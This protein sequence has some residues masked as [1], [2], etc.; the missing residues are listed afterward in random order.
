MF[1]FSCCSSFFSFS[2]FFDLVISS[3]LSVSSHSRPTSSHTI[4]TINQ[5]HNNSYCSSIPQVSPDMCTSPT[6]DLTMINVNNLE[7]KYNSSSSCSITPSEGEDDFSCSDTLFTC[8]HQQEKRK[9]KRNASNLSSVSPENNLSLLRPL[10]CQVKETDNNNHKRTLK[11]AHNTSIISSERT[12]K[13]K[14]NDG[15]FQRDAFTS[16]N[17]DGEN[18]VIHSPSSSSAAAA[19]ECLIRRQRRKQ[20]RLKRKTKSEKREEQKKKKKKERNKKSPSSTTGAAA[21]ASL[22]QFFTL[23]TPTI[24]TSAVLY[25]HEQANSANKSVAKEKNCFPIQTTVEQQ[26]QEVHQTFFSIQVKYNSIISYSLVQS[27]FDHGGWLYHSESNTKEK[28][29][30]SCLCSS[31]STYN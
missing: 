23:D 13:W 7:D 6:Q 24:D 17:N 15:G 31:S 27:R 4:S 18:H 14:Q 11:I 19:A 8:R 22:F 2:C 3:S 12:W 30:C 29:T 20:T 25:P 21:E 5:C 16:N 10:F 26:Q 9:K 1:F 28:R